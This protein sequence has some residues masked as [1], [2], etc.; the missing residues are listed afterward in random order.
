MNIDS[1][2]Q[3]GY[4]SKTRGLKGEVQL[5]ITTDN[6]AAYNTIKLIYLEIAKKLVPHFVTKIVIQ[7]SIAYVYF[8]DVEHIDHSTPLVGKKAYLPLE[9]KRAPTEEQQFINNLIGFQVFDEEHGAIGSILNIIELPQ[10]LI[11]SV[12]FNGTEVLFPINDEIIVSIDQK[13]KILDVVLPNGLLDVY[14]DK[15]LTQE[16]DAE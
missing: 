4:I 1:C 10:Q 2:F 6:P 7:K 9:E 8:E 5:Y 15:N 16:D 13:K 11:A 12:D 14:L 3:L